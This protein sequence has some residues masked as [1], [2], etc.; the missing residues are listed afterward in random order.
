MSVL[1]EPK[2]EAP[3][4]ANLNQSWF[5]FLFAIPIIGSHSFLSYWEYSKEFYS[6]PAGWNRL[7]EGQGAAPQQYR[8]GVILV[9]RSLSLLTHEHLAMRHVLTLLDLLFLGVGIA[10]TFFLV[11]QTRFYHAAAPV[12]RC[13][14]QLLALVLLLFYL[15][16]TFWYHKPET[17][18]NFASLSV[19][20]VLL[21]GKLRIPGWR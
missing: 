3:L 2:D 14:M 17:I 9:A 18:A 10:T 1:D 5:L 13:V 7:L 8:V 15:S 20:A 12:R 16:W 19:A 6:D 21:S 11:R 4:A